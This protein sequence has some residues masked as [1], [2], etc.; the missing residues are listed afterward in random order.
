MAK[1][2]KGPVRDLKR[3]GHQ[4]YLLK[5][6]PSWWR[7]FV[8]SCRSGHMTMRLVILWLVK[9]FMTE[10][11]LREEFAKWLVTPRDK[12]DWE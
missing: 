2:A 7:E 5:E 12:E 8:A 1:E 4:S 6:L 3:L 10:P 9:R 11:E